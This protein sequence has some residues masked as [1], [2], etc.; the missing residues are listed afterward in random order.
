MK[1][2]LSSSLDNKTT[3][4]LTPNGIDNLKDLELQKLTTNYNL[5]VQITKLE[6]LP[7]KPKAEGS[8]SKRKLNV[9][10]KYTV[11]DGDSSVLAMLPDLVLEKCVSPISNLTLFRNLRQNS[12]M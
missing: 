11:T 5:N 12:L 6:E 9:K 10:F 1:A 8:E 3:T 2:P 7:D 4:S